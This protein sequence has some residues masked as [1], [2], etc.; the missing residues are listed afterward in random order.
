M[1]I[2]F[3][4]PGWGAEKIPF[5]D[6]LVQVKN[7]GFDGVE[8]SL[9]MEKKMRDEWLLRIN[10]LGLE[11]I[12]QHHETDHGTY[13]KYLPEFTDRLYWLAEAKPLFINSQTGKDFFSFEENCALIANADE[14][15]QKTGVQI[16]HETHRGKFSFACN[17]MPP[18]L[19]TFPNM[20]IT[21]DFSH[22]VNVSESLLEFQQKTIDKIIPNVYH[23]HSRVGYQEG[24]QVND[25]RA[26]ENKEFLNRHFEWW[27]AII[28][29]RIKAGDSD[30]TITPEFGPQP[31][32]PLLPF[33]QQAVSNQWEINKFMMT[34]LKSRY[35][36]N[37]EI[38]I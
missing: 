7:D 20:K 15:E 32:M 17:L 2:K 24:P 8:I 19:D 16:L 33:T 38:T 3:F 25:P 14:I 34:L 21:A 35:S 9:P 13:Q 1:K 22:W 31:Y 18:Y 36:T 6:F 11:L 4:C 27:D 10:D 23:I 37:G 30:F 28:K 26:P 29:E 5:K 12:V